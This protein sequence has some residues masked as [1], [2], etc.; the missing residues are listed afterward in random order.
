MR[1]STLW[2]QGQMESVFKK[3]KATSGSRR[4]EK[5]STAPAAKDFGLFEQHT[6]GIGRRLMERQGWKDGASLGSSQKGIVKPVE[7]DGQK[8]RERKGLGYYGEPL[9][10]F[11]TGSKRKTYEHATISTVYDRISETDRTEPLLQRNPTTTIKFRNQN[12]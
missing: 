3:P 12:C 6:R 4:P 5:K 2:R 7:S 8:P 9:Q 10:R 1:Q 11:G